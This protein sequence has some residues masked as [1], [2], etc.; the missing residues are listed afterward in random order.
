ME[1]EAALYPP[2][3]RL[4]TSI[5]NYAI[6]T[7]RLSPRH[8]IR[9]ALESDTLQPQSQLGRIQSSIQ[10]LVDLDSLEPIQYFKYPPWDRA[11]P[12]SVYISS[13]PKEEEALAYNQRLA[14]LG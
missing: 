5:R 3:I 7:K 12:Y 10:D 8:L 4:N 1:V 6:R 2:S 13:L 11:I 9:L 14:Q